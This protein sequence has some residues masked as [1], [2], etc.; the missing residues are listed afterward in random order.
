MLDLSNEVDVLQRQNLNDHAIA[1]QKIHH[2]IEMENLSH[3]SRM[4]M[5][6][7]VIDLL[8][9]NGISRDGLLVKVTEKL[10]PSLFLCL[11]LSFSHY[12]RYSVF[13]NLIIITFKF[14][15]ESHSYFIFRETFRQES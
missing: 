12:R 5:E 2:F 3:I 10:K 1:S 9:D 8:V 13:T 4:N 15:R 6:V 7:Q 14:A 11:Y